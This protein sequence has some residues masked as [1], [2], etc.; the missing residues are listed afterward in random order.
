MQIN[1]DD[2]IMGINIQISLTN[3]DVSF[4]KTLLEQNGHKDVKLLTLLQQHFEKEMNIGVIGDKC[5]DLLC[6][7]SDDYD[8]YSRTS[9]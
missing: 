8:P 7:E 9:E 5:L 1:V 2:D 6:E 4:L 3:S